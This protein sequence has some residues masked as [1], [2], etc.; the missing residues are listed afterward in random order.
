M[1]RSVKDISNIVLSICRINWCAKN[2]SVRGIV[3]SLPV[4]LLFRF[5]KHIAFYPVSSFRHI[6]LSCRN[7]V[8]CIVLYG[9]QQWVNRLTRDETSH[10]GVLD[11]QC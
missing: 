4:R 1:M 3:G 8:K 2:P 5:I 6:K 7:R 11:T 9:F 10:T